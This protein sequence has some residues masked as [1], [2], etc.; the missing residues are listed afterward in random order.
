[1]TDQSSKKEKLILCY[2]PIKK[3]ARVEVEKRI[4]PR[5]PIDKEIVVSIENNNLTSG[6]LVDLSG[7]GARL[8][9]AL[10]LKKSQ[11]IE[12]RVDDACLP[13]A[14]AT[15]INVMRSNE[16]YGIRWDGF[17]EEEL[18]KGFLHQEKL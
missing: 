2:N 1:M 3:T 13:F 5:I 15:V 9:T 8:I 6:R 7:S 12:I 10:M 17:V 11:A 16:T 18:P 4:L 14:R